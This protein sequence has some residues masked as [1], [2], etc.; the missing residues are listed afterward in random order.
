M[1]LTIKK[2]LL[3]ELFIATIATLLFY[4]TPPHQAS[5]SLSFIAL[6]FFLYLIFHFP[7]I[8]IKGSNFIIYDE[9]PDSLIKYYWYFAVGL[10]TIIDL[11]L[12]NALLN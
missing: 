5:Y 2:I 12:H 7:I 4:L 10:A 6:M 1:R 3:G 9:A 8:L 11:I